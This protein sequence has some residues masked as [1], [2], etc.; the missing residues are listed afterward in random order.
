MS[1]LKISALILA[2][3]LVLFLVSVAATYSLLPERLA[4]HFGASG[5]PD[6]WM[7]R[8]HYLTSIPGV[9][10]LVAAG[11]VALFYVLRFLPVSL[12]NIPHRDYWL[13]PE[14]LPRV[15]ESLLVVGL[16]LAALELVFFLGIHF[17]TLYANTHPPVHLPGLAIAGLSVASL[18]GTVWVILSVAR[19]FNRIDR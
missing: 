5:R 16:R 6:G 1:R 19:S 13:T 11:L 17:L 3:M 2:G 7:P 15:W 12:L 18:A 14:R 10:L 9:G 4:T 8:S